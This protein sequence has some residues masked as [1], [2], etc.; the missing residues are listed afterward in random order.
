M[1]ILDKWGL[2]AAHR[3]VCS[4]R[5]CSL[6]TSSLEPFSNASMFRSRAIKGQ[7]GVKSFRKQRVTESFPRVWDC[8][9]TS[10]RD[11]LP[12]A[13]E[14]NSERLWNS[15][16]RCINKP[17]ESQRVQKSANVR[18]VIVTRGEDSE[19]KQGNTAVSA[20]EIPPLSQR[21]ITGPLSS[22]T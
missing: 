20:F 15:Q 4:Y 10:L 2:A 21:S 5:A 22:L 6:C 8:S 16:Q 11:I 17:H 13:E 1:S 18:S 9:K 12:Q 3:Q 7:E 19:T 14:T